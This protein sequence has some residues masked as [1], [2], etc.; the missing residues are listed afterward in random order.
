MTSPRTFTSGPPE[1][2]GLI[3]A[4]VW[5]KSWMLPWPRPG[6]PLSARPLALTM[7]EVTVKVRPSPSG[8]PMASTHSPTRASSLLPRATGGRSLA[9]ILS[10]ATSVFGSV[11]MTLRLELPPV[12][13]ADGDLLR[14]LDHVVVGQDVAVGRDDEA[15][16]A[17]LLDLGL[18]P[19]PGEEPLHARAEPA[20]GWRPARSAGTGC[21]PRW[22]SRAPPPRRRP[23]SGPGAAGRPGSTVQAPGRWPRAWRPCSWADERLGRSSRPANSRP[24]AN[25][26]ATRPPNLSQFND[27]ADIESDPSGKRGG[28]ARYQLPNSTTVPARCFGGSSAVSPQSA[29]KGTARG[30]P[31]SLRSG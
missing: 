23:R 24:S 21:R 13:Q 5:M 25:A 19:E 8:L 16:A 11:P 22:A 18:L 15:G 3:A 30:M 10:T 12:E 1:L 27:R 29:A 31:P 26:R 7:P 4:S 9:S 14:A 2:P 17:A 20:A 28:T 6:S